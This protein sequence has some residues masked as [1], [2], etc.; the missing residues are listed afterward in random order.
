ME[1]LAGFTA[2]AVDALA[3]EGY[4]VIQLPLSR[5]LSVS[6]RGLKESAY[7]VDPEECFPPEGP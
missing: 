7:Q 6:A 2:S 4:C 3:K 1:S 5:G